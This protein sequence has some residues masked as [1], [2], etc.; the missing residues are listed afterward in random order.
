MV[1]GRKPNLRRRAAI[2]RLRARGLS[3]A[4]IGRRL[5][6]SREGV[7][8]ALSQMRRPPRQLSVPCS[9]CRAP[10]PSQGALPSDEGRALCLACLASRPEAPFGVRLKAFRLAAGLMKAE[11]A[12]RVGVSLMTI[13]HYEAG[14]RSP[15]W[16]QLV[17]LVRVLGAGLVTLGLAPAQGLNRLGGKI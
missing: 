12:Q 16:A 10:I 6:I 17:P 13:H 5:S 15:R 9:G 3:L 7:S 1:S 11:L 14:A 4:E 2:A 8:Q